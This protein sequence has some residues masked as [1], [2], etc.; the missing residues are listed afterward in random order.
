MSSRIFAP[1]VLEGQV[2]VVTGAGSGL[3]R[4]VA[5]ELAACGA[6]VVAVG[7]RPEPLEET[8]ALCAEGR[9]EAVTCD[10]REE[11]QVAALVGRVLEG[12]GRIDVLV[13]NAGGQF[14]APAEDVSAKCFRA[15]TRLNLEGTWLMTH[16]VATRAMIPGGGGRVVSVTLTPR[17]GMPGMVHSGAARAGVENMTRTLSVEWARFGIRL[18][19]VAAGFFDTEVLAKYPRVMRESMAGTVPVQRLGRPEEI[20]RLVADLAGPAAGFMTG[21]ILPLD[22]GRENWLGPWP[23][24]GMVDEEGRPPAEERRPKG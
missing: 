8:V 20:A 22:G 2:A 10:I 11:E 16:A 17:N 1:G 12:R 19:A 6:A 4:A 21:A 5:V 7:R 24:P 9:C 13:N 14:L 23:P 15:V 18:N 3:G